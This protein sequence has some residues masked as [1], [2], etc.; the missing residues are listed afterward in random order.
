[1][2]QIGLTFFCDFDCFWPFAADVTVRMD[3]ND[4]AFVTAL[5]C[6]SDLSSCEVVSTSLSSTSRLSYSL[7]LVSRIRASTS[8]E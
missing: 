8:I 3:L 7:A 2:A 4:L 6:F 1:M 5:C